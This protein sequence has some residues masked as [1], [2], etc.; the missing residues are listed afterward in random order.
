[1]LIDVTPIGLSGKEAGERLEKAGI[2]V[3]KNAIPNDTR[4]PW[5]PSGIR[6]GT[7]AVTTQGMKERDM[8]KIAQKIK[9]SLTS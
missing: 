8:I 2:I 3:N 6:L 4:K 1:M 5:D 7:P 9:D